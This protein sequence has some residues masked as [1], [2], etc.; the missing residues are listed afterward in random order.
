MKVLAVACLSVTCAVLLTACGGDSDQTSSTSAPAAPTDPAATTERPATT[1][2]APAALD[3]CALVTK[4]QAEALIGTT[5]QDALPVNNADVSS[6]TYPGDP[7]GPTAQVEVFIGAGAKKYYDDDATVLQHAFADV[8]GLGDESHE[9]DYT[10]FFRK[11]TTW[12]ALRVTS[13]DDWSMFKA[14]TE[15]LA[16][17]IASK[18]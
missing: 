10:V 12:V 8:P 15:T 16:K 14:R 4:A 13:L 6:C 2:T 11:G 5:L 9:E 7:T 3:A 17:D 18:I 1:T